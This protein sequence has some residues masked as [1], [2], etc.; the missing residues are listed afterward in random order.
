MLVEMP[1][2]SESQTECGQR[3][4]VKRPMNAFMVWSRIRRKKIA[5][6]YP[7][8]HNSEI[9]KLLGVEWKTLTERE[10][11]P[12]IDE[13][14]R[15]RNQHMVDHPGYKYRPRRKPKCR[16]GAEEEESI[17]KETVASSTNGYGFVNPL[18][19]FGRS[20]YFAPGRNK[21]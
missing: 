20:F 1:D 6:D 18:D 10:K 3:D 12:F 2:S 21:I 13:A 16:P 19:A 15:L 4:H 7:K 11:M 9:S 5:S 17:K 14:K 8:L